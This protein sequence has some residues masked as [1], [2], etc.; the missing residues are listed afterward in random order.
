[1][2]FNHSLRFHS[3]CQHGVLTCGMMLRMRTKTPSRQTENLRCAD[4]T[5][6]EHL[7]SGARTRT[8]LVPLFPGCEL[9]GKGCAC[10]TRGKGDAS[11]GQ[12]EAAYL[13]V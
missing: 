8:P 12:T 9:N 7:L 1:M 2:S 10:E 5:R 3:R 13:L 11:R 4:E 6:G